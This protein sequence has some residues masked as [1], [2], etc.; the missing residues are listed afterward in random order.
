[1]NVGDTFAYQGRPVQFVTLLDLDDS[2]RDCL[3]RTVGSKANYILVNRQELTPWRTLQLGRIYSHRF[4]GGQYRY[5]PKALDDGRYLCWVLSQA[6]GK[7]T[8]AV[9]RQED[10]GDYEEVS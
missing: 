3:V 9:I 7:V 5:I 8:S 1:M 4:N 6:G 10:A 2:M